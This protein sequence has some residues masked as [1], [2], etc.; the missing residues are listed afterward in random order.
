M[1]ADE[2]QLRAWMVGGLGGD[3]GAHAALLRALVPILQAFY[4]RRLR[5][6]DSEIDDLIQETLIAVHTRRATYDRDRA[7]TVWLFAIARYKMVDHFRRARATCP[8]ESIDDI[9]IAEGFEET[10]GAR[11]DIASL[12]ATLPPKQSEAIRRTRIDGLSVAEHAEDAG[13]GESDVKVSVHRGLK[14][15]AARLRGEQ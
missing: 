15:L 3:A 5:G 12:L 6:A 4:R 2:A 1:R 14:A 9:L 11:M 10:S 13:I 8:I 7:F